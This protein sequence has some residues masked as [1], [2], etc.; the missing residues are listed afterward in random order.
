MI[1]VNHTCRLGLGMCNII[2]T[3]IQNT[4]IVYRY[5][6]AHCTEV[7]FENCRCRKII[8]MSNTIWK[9]YHTKESKIL[10]VVSENRYARY[11]IL[12]RGRF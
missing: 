4:H 3:K 11:I 9:N 6:W 7:C 10:Q 5:P 12:L 2:K 8:V 1:N